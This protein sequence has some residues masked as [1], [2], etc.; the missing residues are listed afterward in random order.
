MQSKEKILK[1]LRTLFPHLKDRFKIIKIGIFASYAREEQTEK[2]DIDI[3]IKLGPPFGF[4]S[5]SNLK[6]I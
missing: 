3:L 5:L 2:S 6:I 1:I 4:L